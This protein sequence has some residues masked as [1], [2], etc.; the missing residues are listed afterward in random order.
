M[1]VLTEASGSL[2]SGY[3]IRSIQQAGFSAV[4]SDVDEENAGRYLA[5]DFIR[6]PFKNDPALWEKVGQLLALH[7]VDVVIPS[8][9]EMLL[10]WSERKESFREQGIRVVLS[11]PATIAVCQDKWETYQ[12]FVRHGIPTPATSLEQRYPLVKPREGRGA[13]G[14]KVTAETVGMDGMISQEL[15]TG[16]EY[17]VDVL[18]DKHAVPQ[19]IVPRK[20]LKV[21]E[22]KSTGGVVVRQ[23]EIERWVRAICAKLPFVGPVNMQ[24]FLNDKGEVRFVEINPRIAGGMALGF[25]ATENWIGAI[26]RHLTDGQPIEPKPIQYGMK[27]MR[28]Y[29]EVFI[30]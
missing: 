19:Y 18:C 25:A 17:T 9:D 7:R 6:M 14:V 12:F 22:G 5:D 29:H 26:V 4:A 23:P 1:N 8:F 16:E 21:R 30:P 27:M 20:R 3:L 13:V 2:T 15:L 24:C 11:D 10:G 28:Y